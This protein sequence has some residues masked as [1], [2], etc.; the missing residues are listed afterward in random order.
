MSRYYHLLARTPRWRRCL[1]GLAWITLLVAATLCALW[2]GMA[3]HLHIPNRYRLPEALILVWGFAWL[4]ALGWAVLQRRLLPL[5]AGGLALMLGLLVWWSTITPQ[6][7][8]DWADDVSRQVRITTDVQQPEL[9]QVDHVR[10]F[11]WRSDTD[12]TQQWE[13]RRYDL[14]QLRSVDVALSYWMGPAIAHTLVSF[15]FSDGQQLVFSIEIRKERHEQFDPVAGFFKQYEMVLVAADERDILAVRTNVRD[16][17][18]HLYRVKLPQ[19]EMRELFMAYARQATQLE[20]APRFYHTLTANCTTIIWQL[21]RRIGQPLPTDARLLASGYLPEY[22]R[23]TGALESMQ[24]LEVLRTTG[25]ITARAQQ[26]RPPAGLNDAA[27][28]VHF[29]RH[30]RQGMHL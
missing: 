16:E 19:Q 22:L 10:N 30:I 26:W 23:D 2:G 15:G 18:V 8:R 25:D 28:S 5:M 24:P 9:V 14:R 12:Y 3:L 27:A 7:Q 13:T 11:R 1:Q 4:V 17:Q 29:S 6:T 21:A 20:H